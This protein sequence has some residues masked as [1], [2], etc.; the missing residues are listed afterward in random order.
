MSIPASFAASIGLLLLNGP[1][2]FDTSTLAGILAAFVSGMMSMSLMLMVAKRTSL[3]KLCVG[4]GSLVVVVYL[5]GV[6]SSFF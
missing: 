3:W 4:L 1:S 5:V 2:R 6:W